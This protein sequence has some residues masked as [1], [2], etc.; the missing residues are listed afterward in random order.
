MVDVQQD[1]EPCLFLNSSKGLK[2]WS[3]LTLRSCSSS[4][5]YS[6]PITG[7]YICVLQEATK[8]VLAQRQ[9][10]SEAGQQ[11]GS[12]GTSSS[13]T[14]GDEGVGEEGLELGNTD[15]VQP[16]SGS[17]YLQVI[18]AARTAR[19]IPEEFDELGEEEGDDV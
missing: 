13:G 19:T 7:T 5:V 6:M 9:A 18:R 12:A 16:A 10:E 3:L 14:S 15:A 17:K 4:I 11:E 1:F 2:Q 8:A